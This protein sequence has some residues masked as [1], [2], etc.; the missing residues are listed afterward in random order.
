MGR[1]D[2][3]D[4]YRETGKPGLNREVTKQ[5]PKTPL[6]NTTQHLP[7]HPTSIPDKQPAKAAPS[8]F[9]LVSI[10]N[11]RSLTEDYVETRPAGPMET[12]QVT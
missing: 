5:S 1:E 3:V 2:G 9:A 12:W 10:T 6:N 4:P 8:I 11:F 7:H